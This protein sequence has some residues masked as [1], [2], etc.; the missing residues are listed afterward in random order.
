[1]DHL[2][3]HERAKQLYEEGIVL[4]REVGFGLRLGDLLLSLGYTLILEGDYKQ[5]AALNEQAAALYRNRGYKGGLQWALNNLGWAAL[6]QGDH[7]RA[8]SY[9]DDSLTLCIELG[10]KMFAAECLV[11][12]ACI[13]AAEGEG[14]RAAKLF[15]AAEALRQELGYQH[16]PGEDA[17]REPYYA[18]TRSQL[19]DATW[20]AL[21]AEGQAMSME[22]AVEYALAHKGPT[23]RA[24]ERSSAYEQPDLT[25]REREVAVLVARGLT[26]RQIASELVIS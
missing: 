13:S 23:S 7:E 2:G 4:C 10:D 21:W 18:A 8:R 24:P 22:Q 6:F 12:L 3:D 19:A 16:L 20:N 5:G 9:F 14:E 17:S 25:S 1:M 11:G 26:N 15:A